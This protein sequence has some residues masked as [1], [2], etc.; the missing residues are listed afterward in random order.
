MK[1]FSLTEGMPRTPRVRIKEEL[2]NPG[3]L[4]TWYCLVFSEI[5][6]T[7]NDQKNY[8]ILGLETDSKANLSQHNIYYSWLL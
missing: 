1:N 7:E 8:E 3:F 5:T 6:C 2:A 4:E